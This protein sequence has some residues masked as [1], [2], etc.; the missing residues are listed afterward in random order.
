MHEVEIHS[1][2]TS[3][4]YLNRLLEDVLCENVEFELRS[5][6][7]ISRGVDPVVLVAI[8]SSVSSALT[9]LVSGILSIRSQAKAKSIVL[10]AKDGRR[11]EVPSSFSTARI[12]E[13]I[14]KLNGLEV[15]SII[16]DK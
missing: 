10:V 14:S 3:L 15:K 1:N 6:K 12:D 2:T 7:S 9:A 4:S 11:I 16:L 5:S 13:L 8:I